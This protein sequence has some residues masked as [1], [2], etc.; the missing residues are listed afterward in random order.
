MYIRSKVKVN[1]RKFEF[2]AFISKKN[3]L[4][5]SKFLFILRGLSP[6]LMMTAR[7]LYNSGKRKEEIMT[8]NNFALDISWQDLREN[9]T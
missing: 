9:I 1:T 4:L 5:H 2:T 3:I 7:E 8:N 6:N